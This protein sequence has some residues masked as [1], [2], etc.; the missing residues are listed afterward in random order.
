MG[1]QRT[2]APGLLRSRR[3]CDPPPQKSSSFSS[4]PP[5]SSPIRR[6]SLRRGRTSPA[7]S[8][9]RLP[10]PHP[11]PGRA[12]PHT[13]LPLQMM[14]LLISSPQ[15]E[16]RSVRRRRVCSFVSKCDAPFLYT[17]PGKS[18]V[19][20]RQNEKNGWKS[21]NFLLTNRRLS[22]KINSA[23][24]T[25]GVAQLVEQL[26]CNQQVGFESVHQLQF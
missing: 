15:S 18:H 25:A 16:Q 3:L 24:G 19:P 1:R 26:I 13:L 21:K 8:W 14:L 2:P 22:G 12:G 9:R 20:R 4:A 23:V 6:R 5:R 11:P 10:S 7:A 17:D